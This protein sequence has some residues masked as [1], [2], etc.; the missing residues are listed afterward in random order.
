MT[1]IEGILEHIIDGAVVLDA[2][3]TVVFANPDCQ[4]IFARDRLELVGLPLAQLFT[5]L[6]ADWPS[7]GRHHV[8]ARR[9]NGTLVPLR[10]T[11]TPV[12]DALV[13]TLQ[14]RAYANVTPVLH[15]AAEDPGRMFESIADAVDAFL[16]AGEL[17]GSGWYL[18]ILHGPG[19]DRLL[20]G[21]VDYEDANRLYDTC[22]EPE[23]YPAFERLYDHE[24]R[25]PGEVEEATY[26][27]R[28]LDGRTR[29]VR[30]RSVLRETDG[31]FMLYGVVF[32]ATAEIEARAEIERR[33]RTDQLTG[34]WNRPHLVD[35]LSAELERARREGRLPGLLMVDLDH[36]KPTNDTYGHAVGDTVLREIAQRLRGAVRRYDV[37]ARWGGEEF[38]ILVPGVESDEAVFA[39]AESVRRAIEAAPVALDGDRLLNVTAS[40]GGVLANDGLWSV[41]ALV[42]A[43]DRAL[44]AAKRHGRNRTTL[45]SE[46]TVEDYA[47]EEPE[48]LRLAQA[49]ALS[50]SAR[51]RMPEDHV[52]QVSDLAGQIAV[53]LGL[54]E[55][56]VMRCRLGGWLHDLGKVAIRTG[57]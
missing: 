34:L 43:A 3:A 23:D 15:E 57:C 47:A 33:S 27:L 32:D 1:E 31:R 25:V 26:R 4:R 2:N 18:P 29:W 14:E 35:A 53:R 45:A 39:V 56:A 21:D 54:T 24:R 49:L 8:E 52:R 17:D 51:E 55:D 9:S 40:V 13:V 20:G 46:L 22:I 16:F 30:E 38:G 41:E 36:F 10:A 37:V 48:A 12:G 6:P 42:D 44:Y 5:E 50:A 28:G 11:L 19:L 7:P